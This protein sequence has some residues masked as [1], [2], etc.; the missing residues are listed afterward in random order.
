[1]SDTKMCYK[2]K[3]I[4]S[5]DD[6]H[7]NIST[8]DGKYHKCKP[9]RKEH[10]E[11][12]KEQIKERGREYRYSPSTCSDHIDKLPPIYGSYMDRDDII[13][14]KC[15]KCGEY[16]QP[17]NKAIYHCIA[18]FEGKVGNTQNNLYC[19]DECKD[20]CEVF[21]TRSDPN[22]QK[23]KVDRSRE[24]QPALRKMRLEM[25]D[26]RC[27]R[28]W[29]TED[30]ECHHYEGVEVNPIESADVDNCVILCYNCHSKAHSVCGMGDF[31]RKPCAV[32]HTNLTDLAKGGN[33]DDID[34][35]EE[36]DI[37][38]WEDYDDYKDDL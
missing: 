4:K 5:L 17:T 19:S 16:H 29:N 14:T 27:Q 36:K 2:C 28:C 25:D 23:D 24:V 8:K 1:M 21:G 38:Q 35:I 6:F 9:C 7:N 11:Q 32:I 18:A 37:D 12:N 10:R 13:N 3:E 31:R 34:F 20:T 33:S 26:Y 15:Y 30:L 22:E